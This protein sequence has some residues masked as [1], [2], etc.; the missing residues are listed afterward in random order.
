MKT[1]ETEALFAELF[2]RCS[3][4]EDLDGPQVEAF[5]SGLMPL[6]DDETTPIGFVDYCRQRPGPAAA[7]VSR[8]LGELVRGEDETLSAAAQAAVNA[9]LE[10]SN[11]EPTLAPNL[12]QIGASVLT[13]AWAVTAPFGRSVMLGF[14]NPMA[15]AAAI[16]IADEDLEGPGADDGRHSILVEVDEGGRVTDLQ[17]SGAAEFMVEDAGSVDSR[18][19]VESIAL[20]SGLTRIVHA[21]PDP[22]FVIESPGPGIAANQQFVRHRV[23]D[24]TGTML[25]SIV[26]TEPTV[27]VRRGLTES[28]FAEAN[29]A[30]LS[31][32][33]AALGDL[34]GA[35]AETPSLAAW[36]GVVRGD[37]GEL[38]GRER[39]ALLWLEWADWLGAGIGLMRAG[40][41]AEVSGAAL[42]D[43]V[44]RC[45]EVSS[46]IDK[47]DREYAEWAF[48]VAIDVLEDAGA[49]DAG[50]LTANGRAALVPALVQVWRS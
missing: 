9:I 43:H 31:T 19:V 5:V 30:A 12:A 36:S 32:L 34:D 42:V 35:A 47:A 33:R 3:V 46:A 16:E 18:V 38:S 21:W 20:E 13:G 39:D 44:N 15:A 1:P 23:W 27:D 40:E 22:D 28:E 2:A 8:A 37:G 41:G 14:S 17:L 7:L 50:C 24:A 6:F 49:V 25:A 48:T 29:R 45:P 4:L 26:L 11:T 10:G